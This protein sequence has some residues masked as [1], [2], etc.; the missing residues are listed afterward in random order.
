MLI[1][2]AADK[3]SIAADSKVYLILLAMAL[4]GFKEVITLALPFYQSVGCRASFC[5]P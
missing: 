5:R 2:E 3:L 4:V 1:E